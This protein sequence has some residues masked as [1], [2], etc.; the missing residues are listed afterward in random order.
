[1]SAIPGNTVVEI[2]K[3]VRVNY[4]VAPR[5]FGLLGWKLVNT[6][7][8]E[9]IATFDKRAACVAYARQTMW[10]LWHEVGELTEL[11]MMNRW[12]RFVEKNTY[13]RGSD[14][15]ESKG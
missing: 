6:D 9:V 4:M 7:S 11:T 10:D 14:P 3:Q 5:G 13:P 8:K 2:P 12:G 1:M 15:V